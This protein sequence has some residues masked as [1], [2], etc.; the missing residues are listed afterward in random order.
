MQ[1]PPK[2][3]LWHSNLSKYLGLELEGPC[4]KQ[5]HV[6]ALERELARSLI[7][8]RLTVV[9]LGL[10]AGA[11][12]PEG[13]HAPASPSVLYESCNTCHGPGGEG[14]KGLGA[15]AIAGLPGWYVETSLHKFRTGL[16][17]AHPDDPEGLRMRP[18]SRQLMDDAEVATVA[19]YVGALKPVPAAVATVQGG[20]V[21]AGKKLFAACAA[22][23]G[24]D[25]RGNEVLKAPPIAGQHDWYLR[26]QL[27]K[28]KAGIRGTV[29][30][31][32]GG[33]LMRPMSMTLADEQ[34]IKNV[35]AY[36]ATLT[37]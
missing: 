33:A 10:L 17:G 31:D 35:V 30:G 28:F 8:W 20:D 4:D 9:S 27:L 37:R 13:V 32:T 15:P 12:R 22:C 26:S 6:Q 14:N 7:G 36:V 3:K 34:A 16:R 23:H 21:E 1:P 25:G 24:A 5:L 11:C 2:Q 18:M 19:K 29:P